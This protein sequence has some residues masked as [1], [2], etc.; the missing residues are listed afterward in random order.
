VKESSPA[1][2]RTLT[3]EVH[4]GDGAFQFTAEYEP[5]D[6]DSISDVVG[7]EFPSVVTTP[8]ELSGDDSDEVNVFMLT[9]RASLLAVIINN[10]DEPRSVD[11]VPDNRLLADSVWNCTDGITQKLIAGSKA[12]RVDLDPNGTRLVWIHPATAESGAAE[13]DTDAAVSAAFTTVAGWKRDGFDIEAVRFLIEKLSPELPAG[14]NDMHEA[15]KLSLAQAISRTIAI[16]PTLSVSSNGSVAVIAEVIGSDGLAV[17]GADVTIRLTPG[18]PGRI[19]AREEADGR[20]EATIQRC[21]LPFFYHAAEQK[22]EPVNGKVRLVVSVVAR[23]GCQGGC[24]LNAELQ[25]PQT[26]DRE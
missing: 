17:A 9:D 1:K 3:N 5:V 14:G 18:N 19:R 15:K 26:K 12:C 8:V 21:D 2:T 23:D 25:A 16:K 20:Y 4:N 6:I 22:Y 7:R 13:P 10:A 24:I 11:V